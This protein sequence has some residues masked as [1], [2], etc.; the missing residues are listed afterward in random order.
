MKKV[1][2]YLLLFFSIF[3]PLLMMEVINHLQLK[4]HDS[5]YAFFTVA[6]VYIALLLCLILY[7]IIKTKCTR[8]YKAYFIFQAGINI[9]FTIWLIQIQIP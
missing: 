8:R 4:G 1:I 3:I 5:F 6:I 7:L 2:A 9:I